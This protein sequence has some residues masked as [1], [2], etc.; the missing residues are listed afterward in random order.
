MRADNHHHVVKGCD[1]LCQG[2][3][4]FFLR[5]PTYFSSCF[6]RRPQKLTKSSLSIWHLLCKHQIDGED[7]VN[8]CGLLRNTNF[9]G[10]CFTSLACFFVRKNLLNKS[11]VPIQN[12]LFRNWLLKQWAR[13]V[14]QKSEKQGRYV[15]ILISLTKTNL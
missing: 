7:F 1:H 4:S 6:L 9:I 10:T 11:W 15:S 3:W 14:K 2:R 5:S 13:Y 8:F 12:L